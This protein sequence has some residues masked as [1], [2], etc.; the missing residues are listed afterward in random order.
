MGIHTSLDSADTADGDVAPAEGGKA[1][2]DL[3][4]YP[5]SL[6]YPDT[7]VGNTSI[8]LT[9]MLTNKGYETLP[10]NSITAVGDFSLVPGWATEVLAGETIDVQV[11]FV[12]QGR[13]ALTGGLYIDTGDAAGQEFISLSGSAIGSSS[14]LTTDLILAENA[15]L[16]SAN[17]IQATTENIIPAA[18]AKVLVAVKITETNTA[19]PVQIA[20]NNDAPLTIKDSEGADVGIGDLVQDQVVIGY[21]LD[22]NFRLLIE[23]ESAAVYAAL[24][25]HL[26]QM[27]VITADLAA[28]GLVADEV[29]DVGLIS[30]EVATLAGDLATIQSVAGNIADIVAVAANG[31]NITSVAGN[32]A[33]IDT[34]AGIS[35][36]VTTVA[37][38]AGD[39]TTVAGIAGDVATVAASDA[40]IG[41]VSTNI[42]GVLGVYANM[43]AILDAESNADLAQK[44]A[45]EDEDVVVTGGLFSAKHWAAKAQ[46]FAEGDAISI[47]YSNGTS[48]LTADNVQ[49]AVDELAAEKSDKGHT[50]VIANV[51]GLQGE[52]D[53]KSATGHGHANATTGAA[54]FMSAADK[55]VINGLGDAASKDVGTGAGTVAAGDDSRFSNNAKLNVEDQV[56]TGG[57]RVTSKDLGTI[58]SGTLTLDMGDRPVQHYINDGAHTLEPGAH[59]GAILLDIINNGPGGGAITL[60]GWTKVEGELTTTGGDKFRC[61]ASVGENG[62]LLVIE[63]MQ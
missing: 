9:V 52:L 4:I 36:D 14:D 47:G 45:T 40:E 26:D 5:A 61:H 33:D 23:K 11:K 21:R 51:T 18:N 17:Y 43:A 31:A 46:A 7:K 20:F 50:H 41:T 32:E 39:V 25:A 24:Q 15:G 8:A 56:L 48:G 3:E 53:G 35:G 62:S 19:S 2:Y 22:D 27:D 59:G 1:E 44:F 30:A 6:V 12:P 63:A 28:V 34:V 58:D 16:G 13:G 38:V 49:A 54:G 42:V 10:I 55:T 29:H 60:T 57:V 37:G